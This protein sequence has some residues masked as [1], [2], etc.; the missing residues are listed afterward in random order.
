MPDDRR[1]RDLRVVVTGLGTINASTAGGREAL[2]GAL[3]LGRSAIGPVR[4]FATAGCASGLAAEV[5]EATL[6][7][8]VDRDAA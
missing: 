1:D 8:L 7:S 5:D 6:T 4:A 2:A 3:A